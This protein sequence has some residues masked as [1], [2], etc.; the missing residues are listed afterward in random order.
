MRGFALTVTRSL[1]THADENVRT[2][3]LGAGLVT[4]SL[5]MRRPLVSGVKVSGH[6]RRCCED[7]YARV[8]CITA[9][10]SMLM[11]SL[12]LSKYFPSASSSTCLSFS[13]NSRAPAPGTASELN[14]AEN[15]SRR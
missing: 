6:V 12:Q 3:T 1:S 2:I 9:T 15:S 14:I 11:N 5:E 7:S 13:P 4:A 10:L 8:C